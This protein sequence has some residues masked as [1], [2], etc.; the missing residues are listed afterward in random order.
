MK[1][2][3]RDPTT[4]APA[5]QC[6]ACGATCSANSSI[7]R[8]GFGIGPEVALCDACGSSETP[9]CEELWQRIAARLV[10]QRVSFAEAPCLRLLRHD[11]DA[12]FSPSLEPKPITRYLV[13]VPAEKPDAPDNIAVVYFGTGEEWLPLRQ[14]MQSWCIT[15]RMDPPRGKGRL[16]VV[17]VQLAG[18]ET[19]EE[20]RELASMPPH[21]HFFG[22][23]L[24]EDFMQDVADN[25]EGLNEL[26]DNVAAQHGIDLEKL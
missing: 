24:E 9:T 22:R 23:S 18:N 19:A 1:Y 11:T 8:D 14:G 20:L 2:D 25:G 3:H 7:H 5:N 12:A 13:R 10:G 17:S 4:P 6:A 16:T 26:L 15:R 21:R